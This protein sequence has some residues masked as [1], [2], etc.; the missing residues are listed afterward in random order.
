MKKQELDKAE[1]DFNQALRLSPDY[2]A[3][4][5]NLVDLQV[6][7][8]KGAAFA[9]RQRSKITAHSPRH[10]TICGPQTVAFL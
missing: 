10:E 4:R 7:R 1:A 8:Q 5:G 6:A 3:A 2:P 9:D